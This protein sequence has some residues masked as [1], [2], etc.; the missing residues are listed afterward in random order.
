MTLQNQDNVK[1]IMITA[2]LFS[3]IY[4]S[5]SLCKMASILLK[6]RTYELNI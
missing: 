6:S 5:H 4:H 2:G 1:T 3:C